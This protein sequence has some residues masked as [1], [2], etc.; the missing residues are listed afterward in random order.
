MANWFTPD[1][2]PNSDVADRD[3]RNKAALLLRRFAVGRITNDEF[4]DGAPTTADPAVAAIWDTAWVYYSDLRE[5]RLRGPDRLHPD[6][7]RA[8]VRWI[9]FLDSDLPYRWPAIRHPGNDPE[10]GRRCDLLAWLIGS[11]SRVSATPEQERFTNSGHYPV[12]PF[13]SVR[14]YKAALRNPKRLACQKQ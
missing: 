11:L 10:A 6:A 2:I 13:S 8:W 3:A 14:D 4:E 9:L 5:H 1:P 7:K 12:W